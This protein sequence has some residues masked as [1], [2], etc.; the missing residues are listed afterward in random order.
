MTLRVFA[1]LLLLWPFVASHAAEP[2]PV[3]VTQLQTES[4]VETIEAL[5][6]L[7]SNEQ[8]TLTASVT[9]IV[10]ALHFDD[11]Q[12]VERGDILVEMTSDEEK[13]LVEAAQFALEEAQ[14][15]Y[16]RVQSLA[17]TNL[18]T[19][20]LLDERLEAYQAAQAQLS[21]AQS[22]LADRTIVAPFSGVLG[23]RNISVGA[24]LRPGDVITT[25]DDDSSM[26]LDASIPAVFLNAVRPG[27][28]IAAQSREFPGQTFSGQITA[29][30][31]R[32]DPATRSVQ[33][34][35][36]I[37]NPDRSL[38]SGLLMTVKLE[39]PAFDALLLPEEA[40]VQEGFTSY[41]YRINSDSNPP[42][43]SKVEVHTGTRRQ[44]KVVVE[45][46][47]NAGDQVVSHGVM[48]L[49]DGSP[50]T[51]RAHQQGNESL[52]ALLNQSTDAEK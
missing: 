27:L 39:K 34:R 12:R 40:L 25:L 6:T 50:V 14:R 51:I 32:I 20:S 3:I 13:A 37:P 45:R 22:R 35:A 23:L 38:K 7:R 29:V 10:N 41:V 26:K 33:I 52:S 31:S 49:K 36:T 15:Q 24:L 2:A 19:E 21:V 48:R 28:S 43:V 1:L 44:G 46:G 8:V 42:T 47:L 17:K 18:A 9:D 11:S 16:T 4:F 30:D 5:G